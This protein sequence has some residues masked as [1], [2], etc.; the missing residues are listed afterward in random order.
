MAK[1]GVTKKK[2][3]MF[4]LIAFLIIAV[5]GGG[6]F[7]FFYY[8]TYSNGT[9]SGVVMK[10]SKKGYVFKTWEGE[11]HVDGLSPDKRSSNQL[12]SV[13]RFS[14]EQSER[15]LVQKLENYAQTGERVT[16]HYV[17]RYKTFPWRGDEVYFVTAVEPRKAKEAESQE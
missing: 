5:V 14:V 3:I 11:L 12:S 6:I 13:W 16:L 1:T 10:V 7:S 15:E 17:E 4:S 9:R 8:A 2:V